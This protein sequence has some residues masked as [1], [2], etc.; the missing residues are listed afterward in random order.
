MRADIQFLRGFAV[1]IVLLF[2]AGIGWQTGYLGV[3]VFF[4]I[5]GFLI[6]RMIAGGIERGDFRF[7][8]FYFRRAKRLLPAAFSTFLAT[9]IAAPIFL[10]SGQMADFKLQLIG[11]LAFAANIVL[12]YQTDY[13]GG[14]AHLK[15]LLHIWSLSVEEQYYFVLP[16]LLVFTPRK[17]WKVGAIV[18]VLL[19]FALCL[20]LVMYRP[21]IAFFM[22]PTRAWE[23]GIGSIGALVVGN[24]S[25]AA[26]ARILFYPAICVLLVVPLVNVPGRHPGL[27]A[28][29]ACAAT[30]VVILRQHDRLFE[31]TAARAMTKLGDIS[32]S[33]YLVHWPLFAFLNNTWIGD[34]DET[35]PLQYRLAALAL[36]FVLGYLLHRF[37][38][39]PCRHAPWRLS[40]E[41]MLRAGAASVGLVA[42]SAVIAAAATPPT[43]YK[44]RFRPNSGLSGACDFPS[45]FIQKPECRNSDAP[46]I[47]LWGDS[48]AMALVPG[49]AAQAPVVQ[50]T[51]SMCGPFLGVAVMNKEYSRMWAQECI[52]FNDSVLEYLKN[53]PTVKTVVLSSAID[54]LLNPANSAIDSDGAE[55]PTGQ[56]VVLLGL[57]KTVNAIRETGKNIVFIAPPPSGNFDSARCLERME[58]GLLSLG[59]TGDCHISISTWKRERADVIA[60]VQAISPYVPVINPS[61]FLCDGKMCKTRV[62]KIAI[63]CDRAHLSYEGSMYLGKAMRPMVDRWSSDSNWH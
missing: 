1:L 42:V 35:P 16:A 47:L 53:A 14:A 40:K 26:A 61:D 55:Q 57:R 23:L 32:Y 10:T 60:A 41:T 54:Q 2:H 39:A 49:I 62:D 22:L 3:D 21:S 58:T 37:I 48:F 63:Y 28:L 18:L 33:L 43:D 25:V 59:V 15:P 5:S 20:V 29:L 31:N 34:G 11:A 30:A 51:R 45:T 50:A 9:I 56:A 8:E 44:H 4:V 13:F 17:F 19:S 12:R 7:S 24:R 38:E 36:S 27:G 52:A 6:T 46:K